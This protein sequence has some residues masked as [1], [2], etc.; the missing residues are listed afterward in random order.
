MLV[1]GQCQLFQPAN[2]QSLVPILVNSISPESLPVGKVENGMHHLGRDLEIPS[3]VALRY[4]D[5]SWSS[6]GEQGC[7]EQPKR[8]MR[9]SEGAPQELE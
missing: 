6:G 8:A 5:V 1:P 9:A 3:V 2:T 7:Y 4:K